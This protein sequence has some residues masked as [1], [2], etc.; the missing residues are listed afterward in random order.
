[1][2]RINDWDVVHI[3]EGRGWVRRHR[4]SNVEMPVSPPPPPNYSIVL[5]DNAAPFVT[6]SGFLARE[7]QL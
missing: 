7:V 2:I 4:Y 3:D 6:A 5:P 1:M